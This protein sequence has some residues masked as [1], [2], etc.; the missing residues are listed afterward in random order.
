MTPLRQQFLQDLQLAGLAELT[1]EAYVRAVRQ[2]SQHFRQSPDTL[3]EAQV[4][5]FFSYLK[6]E[7]HFARGSLTIAYSGIKFFFRRTVPRDWKTLV[8][9]RVPPETKLPDVLTVEEVHRIVAATRS[10]QN[11]TC[12]W[13]IYSLGLR[14]SESLSLEVGDIDAA[15]SF[16][17][18]HRG[19]G[20]VDR[21]VP[22]PASTLDLL[23]RYW[24]THRN[25]RL[26]FPALGRGRT[27]GQT[28]SEPL[29]K[30]TIQGTLRRVVTE[31]G[32]K[33]RVAH[34]L[35]HSPHKTLR[36]PLQ[37]PTLP[38]K[39]DSAHFPPRLRRS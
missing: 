30:A 18:V 11:R 36:A 12:L 10:Q 21:Y 24:R 6:N 2:L 13:T 5:D 23:R 34:F 38:S 1:C 33:K 20:S 7:C 3:T 4:R 16:V 19:K 25:A 32:I 37:P 27:Q 29:P 14:L 39:T 17:H 31:L 35:I 28:A 9:L 15:R 26:L 22:L 8:H